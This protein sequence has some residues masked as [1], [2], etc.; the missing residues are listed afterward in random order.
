LGGKSEVLD[1]A[2]IKVDQYYRKAKQELNLVFPKTFTT[3]GFSLK[4]MLSVVNIEEAELIG[5][6]IKRV[7]ESE[8][9]K[10][11]EKVK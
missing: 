3:R 9:P 7:L 2:T 4:C 10:R 8:A 11:V 6:D 1:E 5:V